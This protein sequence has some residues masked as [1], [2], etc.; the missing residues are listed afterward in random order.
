MTYALRALDIDDSLAETHALLGHFLWLFDYDWPAL[1][2]HVDRARELNS[3]SP[4][5]R[6]RYAMGPL[7]VEGRLEEAIAE[8]QA[9]LD[10]DPLSVLMRA[11]LATMFWLDRQYDRAV[12]HG[13]L[14]VEIEP[15]NYVAHWSRGMYTRERGLFEESIASHRKAVELSGGSMLML[16][17]LG[18][19]LGQAGRI[20]GA[21]DVLRQLEQAA[22][23]HVYVPPTCFAWTHLGL[24]DVENAFVWL[25]RAVDVSDRMMVPIQLYPFIDRLRGDARYVALLRKMR[26][27]PSGSAA[28]A[29]GE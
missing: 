19:A 26:L 29:S 4:L 6:L 22:D 10:S 18:L 20:A 1:R 9:A 13:R 2:R 11:W 15:A 14:M 17:W 23:R 28:P 25:D 5:V 27:T 8:M 21:R 16:G 24:G 3:T 12:E 7:L